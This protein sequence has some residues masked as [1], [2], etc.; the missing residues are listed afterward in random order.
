MST[1]T[2][3]Y[4]RIDKL[5]SIQVKSIVEHAK[6]LLSGTT[7][8]SYAKL[9]WN[10]AIKKWLDMHTEHYDYLVNDCGV[11]EEHMTEEYLINELKEKMELYH[12]KVKCYNKCLNGE[13]SFE[14]MLK[15]T[16]QLKKG[17]SGDFLIIKRNNHF[18]VHIVNEIFRS[19]FDSVEEF[20]TVES[21]INYL[22]QPEQ[23]MICDYDDPN[24]ENKPLTKELEQ[25]IR[26]YYTEIGDGNFIVDFG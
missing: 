20:S 14:D 9:S 22:K 21:L 5:N 26:E 7:Y 11:P 3:T 19:Q 4:V 1:W 2:W 13:M 6:W 15:K 12:T 8:A 10:E 18:Y 17:S 16:N 24:L 25:K 23:T